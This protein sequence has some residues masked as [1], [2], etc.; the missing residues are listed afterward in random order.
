MNA[1]TLMQ[2]IAALAGYSISGSSGADPTN[3]SRA[4]RRLNLVKSDIIS[5]YGGKW[6]SNY[7]EGWLALVPLYTTGTIT[8]T[9]GSRA[10]VGSGTSWTSVYENSKILLPDGAYYQIASVTDTTN[11]VLSQPYQGTSFSS[12]VY[13]IWKDEYTLHPEVLTLGGFVDYGLPSVAT[14]AF[15]RDMKDSYPLPTWAEE[16]TVYTNIGRTRL[17]TSYAVGTVT[18]SIN[19]NY[20]VGVSTAWMENVEPGYE[21]TIGSYTYHIK[22]ILSDTSIELYQRLVVAA[23]GSS[24]TAKGKNAL[25]VRFR[26][27]TTQRIVHYWYWAKDY[28]MLNDN[29]EDWVCE[30]YPEV[31]Q[32]GAVVKDYLDKNDVARANMSKMTYENAIKDMRVSEDSSMMGTR[33]LG[34]NVPKE[35]RD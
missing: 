11:I 23:S 10:V 5:R 7:R 29:D 32:Q 28:P 30:I 27:P 18:G 20:L 9:N 2:E 25:T 26:N 31:I 14:E 33:T 6:P 8:V 17:S 16:P 34:Y 22:R 19:D 1:L 12:S 15:P 3:K 21:I 24:Y 13:Q 4:L 35:A